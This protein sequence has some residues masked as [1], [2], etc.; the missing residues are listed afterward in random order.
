M[1]NVQG[2]DRHPLGGTLYLDLVASLVMCYI[3]AWCNENEQV[4]SHL[5]QRIWRGTKI[6]KPS[7]LCVGNWN[8]GSLIDKLRD[9]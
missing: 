4:S 2:S 6:A 9:S 7:R 1:L 3:A 5:T 8:V